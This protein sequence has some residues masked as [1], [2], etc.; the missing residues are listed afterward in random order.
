MSHVFLIIL[1]FH[2][3]LRGKD[4]LLQEAEK[5]EVFNGYCEGTLSF[6]PTYKYDVGSSIY[7]TSSK[8]SWLNEHHL[9]IWIWTYGSFSN[10]TFCV[11]K[12]VIFTCADKGAFLDRQDIVQGWPFFRLGCSLELIWVPRLCSELRPQACESP[13]LS[14]ST[15][16]R[17]CWLMTAV[18][19]HGWKYCLLICC[20]RTGWCKA[21]NEGF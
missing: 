3:K 18:I 2:Q 12:F 9:Q 21:Q 10:L 1:F 20:E 17:W 5:G 16:W 7:D 13:S 4:Q 6:K 15:Q 19:S 14:Q 8:V 11:C